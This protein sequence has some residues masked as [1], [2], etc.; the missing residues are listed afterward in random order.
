MHSLLEGTFSAKSR[1]LTQNKVNMISC[2]TR[3]DGTL[4]NPQFGY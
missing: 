2:G 4:A 1:L 3:V